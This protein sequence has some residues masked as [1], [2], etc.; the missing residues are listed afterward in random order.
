LIGPG[1]F[2]EVARSVSSSYQTTLVVALLLVFGL[3]CFGMSAAPSPLSATVVVTDGAMSSLAA[4]GIVV[5]ALFFKP[6]LIR[7]ERF[8]LTARALDMLEDSEVP[9]NSQAS[10]ERLVLGFSEPRTFLPPDGD[11]GSDGK[12]NDGS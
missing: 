5:Y 1:S 9:E 7:S 12:E 3:V 4:L 2:R 6:E 8:Q 11:M 10:I